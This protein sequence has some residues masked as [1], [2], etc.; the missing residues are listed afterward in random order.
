VLDG[1]GPTP[2]ALTA[3]LVR[4]LGFDRVPGTGPLAATVPGAFD[5]WITL[6][7]RWGRL[8]PED[9]LEPAISLAERGV[10]VSADVRATLRL[11][12]ESFARDWPTSASTYLAEG[13]PEVGGALRNRRLASTYRRLLDG[14]GGRNR[15]RSA[16]FDG[17]RDA[18][19]RGFV[20]EE[21]GR[22]PDSVDV[23]GQPSPR[24]LTA[25]DLAGYRVEVEPAV[26]FEYHGVQVSKPGPWSQGPVFLQQLAL[27][28]ALGLD[29]YDTADPDVL[30]L[31]IEVSKLAFADREAWY[32]DA[33]PDDVPMAALLDRAY[34]ATRAALIDDRASGHLR[35]GAPEGR[36]PR[37]PVPL[38]EIDAPGGSASAAFGEPTVRDRLHRRD[39]CHV[40]A[41]DHEGNL[42]AAMPSGGWLQSSPA[43][44]ELGFALGTRSQMTWLEAGLASSLV[45]GRRPRTTLSPTL[46]DDGDG[47]R[48]AFG[49]PG[50]DRQDQWALQFF[51]AH[52]HGGQ[53][54]QRAAE[55]PTFHSSH[56]PASFFPRSAAPAVAHA[57][58]RIPSS[59]I[60]ELRSRGHEVLVEDDWSLGRLTAVGTTDDGWLIA[61]SNPRGL[62]SYAAGR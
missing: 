52:L 45:P 33:G 43:I 2:G 60:E 22:M 21:I 35:P 46:A 6:A 29:R 23:Q 36:P 14:A 19:Y 12:G 3:E 31:V 26:T 39:T 37:L 9:L 34:A 59:T 44:G 41:V 53:D 40:D 25:E 56:A 48:L 51:L 17:M 27:L 50:G 4:D 8:A 11:M 1:Q 47:N 58:A 20:A 18:F 30:H 42:V 54:I 15:P 38:P 7:Q 55:E 32:G 28:E 24:L 5:A 13:V 10:P 49:T 61:A 57:E 62:H 16:R